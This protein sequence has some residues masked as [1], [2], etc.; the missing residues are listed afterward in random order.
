MGVAM[1]KTTVYT[2]YYMMEITNLRRYGASWMQFH[3]REKP[4]T[5]GRTVCSVTVALGLYLFIYLGFNAAFNSEYV[6]SRRV[7]LWAEETS[8]YSWSRFCTVKSAD[9]R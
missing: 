2:A 8:T 6:M 1:P 5:A 7:V 3:H 4:L 9:H